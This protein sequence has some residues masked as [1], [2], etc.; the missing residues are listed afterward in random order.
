MAEPQGPEQLA[1]DERNKEP[2]L[3]HIQSV[4]A[5]LVEEVND[6]IVYNLLYLTGFLE[7][8]YEDD[9]Y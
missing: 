1:T 2:Q 7:E 6:E 3:V 8:E 9:T 5:V 4:C